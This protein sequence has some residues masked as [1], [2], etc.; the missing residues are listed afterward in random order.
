MK[1]SAYKKG[2]KISVC[3][4]SISLF[5]WINEGCYASRRNFSNEGKIVIYARG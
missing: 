3:V 5:Q 2:E 1:N 4:I